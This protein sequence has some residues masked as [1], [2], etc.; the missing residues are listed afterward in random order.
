MSEVLL[1]VASCNECLRAS[2]ESNL[3]LGC[4][5]CFTNKVSV[6]TTLVCMTAGA[7]MCASV[8]SVQDY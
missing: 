6:I 8:K 5:D 4:R 2:K 3:P 7:V 1:Y